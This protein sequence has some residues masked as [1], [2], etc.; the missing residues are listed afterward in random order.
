MKRALL[1][2]PLKAKQPFLAAAMLWSTTLEHQALH[3][4]LRKAILTSANFEMLQNIG[5]QKGCLICIPLRMHVG[6]MWAAQIPHQKYLL[7]ECVTDE[8]TRIDFW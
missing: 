2:V 1:P 7:D 5:I 6:Q 3:P 8:M 4:L